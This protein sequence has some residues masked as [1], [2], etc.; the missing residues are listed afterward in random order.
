[1]REQEEAAERREMRRRGNRRR[2]E[3]NGN[4]SRPRTRDA[5]TGGSGASGKTRFRA[6]L[7]SGFTYWGHWVAVGQSGRV[8]P[9]WKVPTVDFVTRH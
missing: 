1:M 7:C 5:G 8:V 9:F 2:R 6:G 4:R 3:M